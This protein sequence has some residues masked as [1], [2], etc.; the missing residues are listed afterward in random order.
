MSSKLQSDISPQEL[1]RMEEKLK[2]DEK[3]LQVSHQ[4]M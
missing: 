4:C 2:R 3:A 1:S